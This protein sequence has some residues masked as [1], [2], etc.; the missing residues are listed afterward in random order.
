MSNSGFWIQQTEDARDLPLPAYMTPQAA[1][2]DVYANVHEDTVIAKGGIKAIPTGIRIALPPDYEAQIRPRSGLA[3]KHGITM[4]NAVGTVDADFRGE[5]QVLLV[6]LGQ[7][8]FIIR[9]G[10]RIAQMVINQIARITWESSDSLED[11][12]R[13]NGGF[14]H[15][16]MS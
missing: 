5:V 3:L 9:R 2:M 8:D 7:L 15:T 4:I 16:G 12:E 13:G 14:G 6:N 11:T 10:D 1:G